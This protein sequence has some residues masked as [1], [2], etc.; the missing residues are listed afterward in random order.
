MCMSSRTNANPDHKGFIKAGLGKIFLNEKF[1]TLV[2]SLAVMM[3]FSNDAL[4]HSSVYFLNWVLT[5]Y[6]L[7][8]ASVKIDAFSWK[9][10]ISSQKNRFD[11]AILLG[12]LF[13]LLFP[14][15]QTSGVIFLRAFQILALLRI[16]RLLSNVTTSL[17][18]ELLDV[19]RQTDS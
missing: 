10:Y 4:S 3:A 2:I 1:T 5:G 19:F 18:Y 14:A 13:L 9:A 15:F 8:E 11:F 17:H 7:V 12:S 16:L 6:F